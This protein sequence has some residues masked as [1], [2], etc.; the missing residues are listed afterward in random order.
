[1]LDLPSVVS[2]ASIA[3]KHSQ[4]IYLDHAASTPCDPAVV[5]I[6]TQTMKTFFGNASSTHARGVEASEVIDLARENIA[7]A[8]NGNSH[9]VIFTSG[10]TES[11]NLVIQGVARYVVEHAVAKRK[12]LALAIE[13]ASVLEPI[14]ALEKQGFEYELIKVDAQ[15]MIDIEKFESSLDDDTLLCCIQAA[16]NE[17][18]TVQP[19]AKVAEIAHEHGVLVHCDAAQALGKIDLNVLELGVDF[20][21]LSAHKCYGPM[22]IGSL[23]INGGVAGMPILPITHGGGQEKGLRPG[24]M[25]TVAIAGFGH[26]AS[27]IPADLQRKSAILA[28]MRNYF[29][30]IVSRK[31]QDI[32]INGYGSDRLPGASSLTFP[33]AAADAVITRLPEF[34][35][36]AASACH[37][38]TMEPSHV[39]L[40]IGLGSA[41]AYRT[42]RVGFGKGNSMEES[43]YFATRLL[44]S[45]EDVEALSQ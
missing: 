5:E 13:H 6:M 34:D 11:N 45:V 44:Q 42:L 10:A 2:L 20:M 31:R 38:S 30:D 7:T 29:E 1:M 4:R 36:S 25:N 14:K 17:I 40:A 15:G 28:A 16:N 3:G 33:Q 9:E 37:S 8:I 39:L 22:G 32:V 41:A 26:A 18:G 35:L 12:I 23:W 19:V 21:S 43:E 24:T 27:L